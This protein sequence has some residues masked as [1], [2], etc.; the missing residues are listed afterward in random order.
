M[1]GANQIPGRRPAA[2]I[3]PANDD[4]SDKIISKIEKFT[5]PLRFPMTFLI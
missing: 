1:N 5:K 4:S 2:S 3:T